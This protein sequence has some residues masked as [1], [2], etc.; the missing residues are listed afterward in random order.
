[1]PKFPITIG[2]QSVEVQEFSDGDQY[3]IAIDERTYRVRP[4]ADPGFFYFMLK[5]GGTQ[6][7]LK[8]TLRQL[9]ESIV[10]V[11]LTYR[12]YDKRVRR[13]KEDAQRARDKTL[14]E[15]AETLQTLRS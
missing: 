12:S 10:G 11:H 5:I 9:C 13:L 4:A 14:H 6:R 7:S 8:G 2:D 15:I 1:M 3:I